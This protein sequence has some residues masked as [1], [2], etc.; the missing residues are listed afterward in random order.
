MKVLLAVDGSPCSAWATDEAAR[1]PW[2]AGSILRVVSAVEPFAPPMS[3]SVALPES[4]F[5]GIDEAFRA[6][7]R[8][9]IDGALAKPGGI[10]GDALKVEAEIL[11]GPAARAILDEAEGWGADLVVVGS[12]GYGRAKRVLLGSV[13]RAVA[14]RATCSVEIVRRREGGAES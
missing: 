2:P 14:S 10:K 5:E 1:L 9:A 7:A 6:N 8:D 13:S 3:E 11:R 12:H 4:Y